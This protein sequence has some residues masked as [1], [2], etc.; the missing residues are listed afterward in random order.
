MVAFDPRTAVPSK[1]SLAPEDVLG[2]VFWTRKPTTLIKNSGSLKPF[3]LVIHMTITG[4]E[5]VEIGAP[6]MHRSLDLMA[7]AVDVFGAENVTWRFSPIPA[8]ED[9]VERFDRI[10]RSVESLGIRS[11]YVAFLQNNDLIPEQRSLVTR[12]ELLLQMSRQAKGMQVLVCNEDRVLDD[13]ACPD[14]LGYGVCED[15]RRF[16]RQGMSHEACG[17]AHS[18]DPFTITE[19]CSIGC[20]YC[21]AADKSLAATKKNTTKGLWILP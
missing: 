16:K 11:V 2:L 1:W 12:Q 13:L 6:D 18:V 14:N 7:K 10:A 8:V 21:Y 5:E 19:A 15:G 9:M 20:Q 3:P 4:W 17:C